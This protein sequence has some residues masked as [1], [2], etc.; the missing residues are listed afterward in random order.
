MEVDRRNGQDAVCFAA[1]VRGAYFGAG[2]IH[3]YLAADR[4]PP[5]VVAGIST[6]AL[7]AA[8]MYKAYSELRA[9]PPEARETRR[10]SWYRRYLEKLTYEPLTPIWDSIPNPV[11]FFAES[12][13][14]EDPSCPPQL[15]KDETEAR[16]QYQRLIRLGN[17]VSGLRVTVGDVADVMVRYVRMRER[18]SVWRWQSVLLVGRCL[19]I[20]WLVMWQLAVD[21]RIAWRTL[22]YDEA[23]STVERELEPTPLFGWLWHAAVAWLVL[24]SALLAAAVLRWWVYAVP[25]ALL[26]MVPAWI[27]RWKPKQVLDAALRPLGLDRGFLHKYPMRRWLLDLFGELELESP[28][29][30][31]APFHLLLVAT[32]LNTITDLPSRQLWAEPDERVKIRHALAAALSAPGLFPAE[33]VPAKAVS[34]GPRASHWLDRNY[35]DSPQLHEVALVDASVMR[36]NPLPAF[37]NWVKRNWRRRRY[38]DSIAKLLCT[39]EQPG[40]ALRI[41]YSVPIEPLSR[42]NEIQSESLNIVENGFISVGL[43][44]RRDTEME[45]RQTRFISRLEAEVQRKHPERQDRRTR[46]VTFPILPLP[47]SPEGELKFENP[48]NPTRKEGLGQVAAGC[49]RTLETI[50]RQ[51]LATQAGEGDRIPCHVLLQQVAPA[52]RDYVQQESPGLSEVCAACQEACSKQLVVRP[53]ETSKVSKSTP[54]YG[55]KEGV[56]L[57]S[58]FPALTGIESRVVFLANGGV[59][60]GSFH[61]GVAAAMR[62]AKITPDLVV[63]SS[64]GAIIGASVCAMSRIPDDTA[65]FRYVGDLADVFLNCDKKVALTRTLKSASRLLGLLGRSVSLSPRQLRRLVNRGSRGDSGYAI[66]G[67]PAVLI[68]AISHLFLLPHQRTQAIAAKFVAGH[69]TDAAQLFWQAVQSETLRRLAI[70]D[71]VMGADLLTEQAERLLF[72]P[73]AQVSRYDVQPYKGI[74]FFATATVLSRRATVILGRDF[75]HEIRSP[76]QYDFLEACLASS[77]FPVVFAPR[78][79]SDLFPGRGRTDALLCDGGI[80]DNLPFFPALRVMAEIQKS[81][82][83]NRTPQESLEYLKQRQAA[84]ALVI[85]AGLDSPAAEGEVS[86]LIDVYQLSTTLGNNL[87]IQSFLNTSELVYGMTNDLVQAY[88]KCPEEWDVD[89]GDSIVSNAVLDILPRDPEHLNGTFAFCRAT[90]LNQDRMRVSIAHG[91][92]QT[93][94]ALARTPK[95][96][97]IHHAMTSCLASERMAKVEHLQPRLFDGEGQCPYFRVAAKRI[98]C[99][100]AQSAKADVR[101]IYDACVADAAHL[102]VAEKDK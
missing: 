78:S 51:T 67:A 13:Q 102:T 47:I 2:V 44:R 74:G 94:A 98:Q 65:A 17:W 21:P 54:S 41:V 22:R 88:E 58:E 37:F 29:K 63:G 52:R 99:P 34:D 4:E 73:E 82:G 28:E 101:A 20:S 76:D 31:K 43:Q 33:L 53:E 92:F 24:C 45:S 39:P 66:A 1:G 96:T 61:I 11:E 59:F 72:P 36:S 5:V 83:A 40:A 56:P 27:V 23:T 50:F 35:S 90:G 10:W 8:A 70:E 85:A 55:L 68:D 18:Y 81:Y 57:H 14:V 6:G 46:D 95:R 30:G 87:K 91:C 9:A 15:K 79:V 32:P 60:R 84:P 3:A 100:F 26:A 75:P 97:A 86:A 12:A 19:W 77:A 64:V 89:L 93:L 16:V 80:F 38:E 49:R 7:T 62:L 42:E 25:L 71:C 48:L 69:I